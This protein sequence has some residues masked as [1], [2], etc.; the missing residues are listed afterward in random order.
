VKT[1]SSELIA[2][3][4][5]DWLKAEVVTSGES[6]NKYLDAADGITESNPERAQKKFDTMRQELF[7]P[8]FDDRNW[9]A[10]K[11]KSHQQQ[12][13][14]TWVDFFELTHTEKDPKEDFFAAQA[15]FA[16]LMTTSGAYRVQCYLESD[17]PGSYIDLRSKGIGVDIECAV[18]SRLNERLAVINFSA[19]EISFAGLRQ[20]Y[21]DAY[22]AITRHIKRINERTAEGMNK[23]KATAETISDMKIS[24]VDHIQLVT[25]CVIMAAKLRKGELEAVPFLEPVSISDQSGKT[26][27]PLREPVNWLEVLAS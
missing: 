27:Y 19:A 14:P 4:L 9:N 8:Y 7:L 22:S 23:K 17:T 21:L 16:P 13:V 12:R 20:S 18:S 5:D 15:M 6:R 2:Q 1:Q 10:Q 26:H 11:D 24:Q 25:D 3:V